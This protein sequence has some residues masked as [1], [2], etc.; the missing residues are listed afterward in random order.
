[1][2]VS[3]RAGK[4]V[5]RM[6]DDAFLA[7]C[8]SDFEAENWELRCCAGVGDWGFRSLTCGVLAWEEGK[9]RKGG[10]KGRGEK[11]DREDWTG[12]HRP[13]IPLYS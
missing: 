12:G 13:I 5:V 3:R 1:M 9:G 8:V 6:Y 7:L 10:G 4:E 2:G 11:A